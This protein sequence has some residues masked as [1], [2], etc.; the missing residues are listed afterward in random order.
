M[1]AFHYQLGRGMRE[2]AMSAQR[3]DN[4]PIP[5]GVP[6]L[7]DCQEKHGAFSLAER[8]EFWRGWRLGG[9]SYETDLIYS[10]SRYMVASDVEWLVQELDDLLLRANQRRA[11]NT[12]HD[13]DAPNE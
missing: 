11:Q 7:K 8:R 1:S 5:D 6:A 3:W 10:L 13:E 9:V 4:G 2:R 12:D